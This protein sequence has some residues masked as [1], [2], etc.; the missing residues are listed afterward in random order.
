MPGSSGTNFMI[1]PSRATPDL[2]M[3]GYAVR[4]AAR[5]SAVGVYE[6]LRKPLQSKALADCFGL[7]L[8][9]PRITTCCNCENCSGAGEIRVAHT[10]A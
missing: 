4:N 6:V 10:S 5:A 8:R 9:S 1:S 2:L 3:I 7:V